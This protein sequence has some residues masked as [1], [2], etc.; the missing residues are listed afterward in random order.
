IH[1]GQADDIVPIEFSEK[2]Y[3]KMQE[4]GRPVELFT[5]PGE[6]HTFKGEGWELAME[7]VLAF[8]DERLK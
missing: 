5:Y 8:F 1:H 6:V 2:L 7:R 4:A 3:A